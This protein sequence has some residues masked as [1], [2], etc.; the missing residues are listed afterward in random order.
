MSKRYHETSSQISG[1]KE[2]QITECLA[3][4][5]PVISILTSQLKFSIME[6]SE[7]TLSMQQQ[8]NLMSASFVP[9]FIRNQEDDDQSFD[10]TGKQF[11]FKQQ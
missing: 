1:R 2:H 4:D 6:P 9:N 11:V 3:D 7:T 5:R 8:L 10:Q